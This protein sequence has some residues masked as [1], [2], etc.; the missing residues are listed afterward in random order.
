MGYT[1]RARTDEIGELISDLGL[2]QED[3]LLAGLM[4]FWEQDE[5]RKINEEQEHEKSLGSS[6]IE[7]GGGAAHELDQWKMNFVCRIVNIGDRP[8]GGMVNL[9]LTLHRALCGAKLRPQ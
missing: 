2:A 8:S 7:V 1:H 5:L 9:S 3:S 6:H 4:R